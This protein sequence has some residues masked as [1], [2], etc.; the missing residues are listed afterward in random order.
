[1]IYLVKPILM[2]A[3]FLTMVDKDL[4][5]LPFAVCG[6]FWVEIAVACCVPRNRQV[7]K[8]PD[9]AIAGR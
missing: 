5:E 3:S 7:P 2:A 1:M 4:R 6:L 9:D 8:L